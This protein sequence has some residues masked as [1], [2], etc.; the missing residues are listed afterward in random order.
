MLFLVARFRD[1]GRATCRVSRRYYDVRASKKIDVTKTASDNAPPIPP[2][3]R[4]LGVSDVPTTRTKTLSELSA[5]FLNQEKQLEKRRHLCVG[6]FK[7]AVTLMVS[8]VRRVK[9]ASTGYFYDLH[10]TRVHGGKT[11][12]APKVLIREDVR[13]HQPVPW[14]RTHWYT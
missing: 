2:L 6:T 3:S 8:C 1:S 11:W 10:M 7:V 14:Y 12:M 13:V 4:P 5:D 9:E